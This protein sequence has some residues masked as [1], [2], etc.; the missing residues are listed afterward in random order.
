MANPLFYDDAVAHFANRGNPQGMPR[1]TWRD[2]P[3][4]DPQRN[5]IGPHNI[6]SGPGV[7]TAPSQSGQTLVTSQPQ[8]ERSDI[9]DSH[10][11]AQVIDLSLAVTTTSQK[12]L[13][14]PIGR[15]NLLMLRN[16]GAADLAIAFGGAATLTSTLYL[17]A[18]SLVLFDVVVPQDDLY[19]IG[20]ATTTLSYSYSTIAA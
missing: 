5:L 18:G 6:P 19:V 10:H 2:E 14:A 16:S 3:Y 17:A 13:D 1:V 7:T 4:R 11:Y 8:P 12:F 20:A 15:R 9:R